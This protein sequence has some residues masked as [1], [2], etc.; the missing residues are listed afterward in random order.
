MFN[1]QRYAHVFCKEPVRQDWKAN[2]YYEMETEDFHFAYR[3]YVLPN[4]KE[5]LRYHDAVHSLLN[6]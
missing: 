4:G 5:V 6:H 2:G 1:F 3:V